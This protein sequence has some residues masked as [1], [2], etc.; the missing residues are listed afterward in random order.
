MPHYESLEF[1][2]EL[3][4][5]PEV[6]GTGLVWYLPPSSDQVQK[7][8]IAT[9]PSSIVNQTLLQLTNATSL[10]LG[11]TADGDIPYHIPRTS[12]TLSFYYAEG[13]LPRD[14]VIA[15]TRGAMAYVSPQA[16]GPYKSDT[17]PDDLFQWVRPDS[18]GVTTR[19][20]V[21]I[22]LSK[23]HNVSW[24]QLYDVLYGLYQF[25]TGMN[26]ARPH[27]ETLGFRILDD[28]NGKLGVGT[29][30][31]FEP[32]P[33][34]VERRAETTNEKLGESAVVQAANSTILPQ[35]DS[36]NGT[37]LQLP[38]T[39]DVAPTVPARGTDIML[40]FTLFD[41]PIIPRDLFTVL[42][43]AQVQIAV[44]VRTEPTDPIP[45]NHFRYVNHDGSIAISIIA[46]LDEAISW[47]QL[48]LILNQLSQY[49]SQGHTQGLVFEIDILGNRVGFGVLQPPSD[50]PVASAVVKRALNQSFF[51]PIHA[52]PSLSSPV[53]ATTN[54]VFPITD[55]NLAFRILGRA[56]PRPEVTEMFERA[57]KI[58][59]AMRLNVAI[60]SDEFE[61]TYVQLTIS[62]RTYEGVLIAWSQL[63]RVIYGLMDFMMPNRPHLQ[64]H[65]HEIHFQINL[66]GLGRIGHG[67]VT[68]WTSG[69]VKDAKRALSPTLSL[70]RP[71]AAAV[72]TIYPIPGTPMT[73]DINPFG[74]TAISPAEMSA[75][76]TGALSKIYP[77]LA[78]E[79]DQ[80]IPDNRWAY[81]DVVTHVWLSIMV[82]AE[83]TLSWQQLSWVIT[84]LLQWMTGPGRSDITT[85]SFDFSLKGEGYL[86]MGALASQYQ[87]GGAADEVE[88][89]IANETAKRYANDIEKRSTTANKTFQLLPGTTITSALQ[90]EDK[91][92]SFPWPI[93]DTQITLQF[94]Y[95]EGEVPGFGLYASIMTENARATIQMFVQ[96]FPHQP[97]PGGFFF[98]RKDFTPIPQTAGIVIHNFRGLVITWQQL[99]IVL[100]G[101]SV[102]M[103]GVPV[104][105]AVQFDVDQ[106]AVGKIG[107]GT[108]ASGTR[109]HNVEKRAAP[110]AG[111]S[112]ASFVNN[113]ILQQANTTDSSSASSTATRPI[114]LHPTNTTTIGDQLNPF[115]IPNTP[116]TLGFNTLPTPIPAARVA[117]LWAGVQRVIQAHVALRPNDPINPSSFFYQ[118]GYSGSREL[119]SIV[120]RPEPG[121]H[122]T[123]LQLQQILLG[124]QIVMTGRGSASHL[125]ALEIT[126]NILGLGRVANGLLRYFDKAETV[127][128]YAADK[129]R[130]GGIVSSDPPPSTPNIVERRAATPATIETADSGNDAIALQQA[131]T[132][133]STPTTLDPTI[134]PS[135]PP[136][137][138][139]HQRFTAY[140][141]PNTPV[142]LY[143]HTHKTEIPGERVQ[144]LFTG[145]QRLIHDSLVQHPQSPINP[146]SFYHE[147]AYSGPNE[148]I[149][150]ALHPELAHYLTW[151]ELSQVLD[152]L[153]TWMSVDPS[154]L[155]FLQFEVRIAGQEGAVAHGLLSYPNNGLQSIADL[156]ARSPY[157]DN[158]L[159]NTTN[160]T[161]SITYPIPGTPI[162]LSFTSLLPG[163][164][165]G[166]RVS[167]LF[168]GAEKSIH[169]KV[170]THAD[171]PITD[172]AFLYTD[173]WNPPGDSA[174]IDI[175][176]ALGKRITWLQLYRILLG[177]ESFMIGQ[178]LPP[179]LQNLQ[180]DIEIH[181]LGKIGAGVVNYTPPSEQPAS[182]IRYPIPSTPITLSFT[183][184]LPIPIPANRVSNLLTNAQASVKGNADAS[185]HA[186]ITG[187]DFFSY[188]YDYGLRAESASVIIHREPR[189][190]V[191]WLQLYEILEALKDFMLGRSLGVTYLQI[192]VFEVEIKGVGVVGRGM[193]SYAPPDRQEG[194]M[195][196]GTSLNATSVDGSGSSSNVT[197]LS[198]SPGGS[199]ISKTLGLSDS[200]VVGSITNETNDQSTS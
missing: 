132:I 173:H 74:H 180:F 4:G 33:R 63:A 183:S 60:P 1:E 87:P 16:T 111:S 160:L 93:P 192:L 194:V 141:V 84:G 199:N 172:S 48:H 165:P 156:T 15:A 154:R 174:S 137:N 101:L 151:T 6:A 105:Q 145:A 73:L 88:K 116:I 98:Y 92:I 166:D 77:H 18:V 8:A 158:G 30:S 54:I 91:P 56:L 37:P 62:V 195:G 169:T 100:A 185:P 130:F 44:A 65:S 99:D 68:S 76:M 149:A 64:S 55:G 161:A 186:P 52:T 42:G 143:I 11:A 198:G 7:R 38:N 113:D 182:P 35:P 107:F 128:S 109:I 103:K 12:F 61:F 142:T 20:A 104:D 71:S 153:Q 106:F 184:L 40:T 176:R 196:N 96:Q 150:L 188:T 59:D 118:L 21:T 187:A 157:L 122:L 147:V 31:Y 45:N 189:G 193:V 94:T 120:L 178:W 177:L 121:Y 115:P 133:V 27:Y 164:I 191:T 50:P 136:T 13:P 125:L 49:C 14:E 110:P 170:G 25:A 124:V 168:E 89:K 200:P 34:E 69:T 24:K 114:S 26:G 119:I 2:I 112:T 86:G 197:S 134:D 36:P 97:L 80:A 138:A 171:I 5:K 9:A 32:E 47:L 181:G 39:Q 135:L 53:A 19:V 179:H 46:Y 29:L 190:T 23:G 126:V 140:P 155:R 152:G 90:G 58:V 41:D 108:M 146:T 10:S 3:T 28:L 117:D 131:N 22:F 129:R 72:Y 43:A 67:Y 123:W 17:I 81:G 167:K 95:V 163:P 70:P 148:L 51:L 175:Y 139:T 144:E 57:L 85:L 75:A 159:Q 83:S 66:N 78:R 127:T 82:G 102:F 162:T 79:G